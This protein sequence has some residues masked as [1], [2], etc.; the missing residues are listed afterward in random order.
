M[1]RILLFLL[2]L[3][4]LLQAQTSGRAWWPIAWPKGSN[5]QYG[6]V[7]RDYATHPVSTT[8]NTAFFANISAHPDLVKLREGPSWIQSARVTYSQPSR[9]LEVEIAATANIEL[10]FER[11]D[12]IGV[13]LSG[14]NPDG[15]VLQS[16]TY[17][18]AGGISRG[19]YN[20][21]W[22]FGKT[23]AGFGTGIPPYPIK[24]TFKNT[25]NNETFIQVFRPINRASQAILFVASGSSP[26]IT[27]APSWVSA[28]Y[29]Y[30]PSA[31]RLDVE[32]AG[33]PMEIKFERVDNVP[34]TGTNPDGPSLVNS[35][36]YGS[37]NL[38][39]QGSYNK[40]WRWQKYDNGTGGIPT[41]PIRIT[42][43][44]NS[45]NAIYAFV[46]TPASVTRQQLFL[47]G[48]TGGGTVLCDY[49]LSTSNQSVYCGS[50]ITLTVS[51]T[52]PDA[53]GVTYTW[54]GNGLN[55]TGQSV[56]TSAPTGNGSYAYTVTAVKAN[57]ANKTATV[58]VTVGG[59]SNSA[60]FSNGF[61]EG[62]TD[63]LMAYAPFVPSTNQYSSWPTG[64]T[65]QY[66]DDGTTKI[67]FG[68]PI[69][70][71]IIHISY[72]GGAN[73]VNTNFNDNGTFE[74]NE[75]P[76]TGRSGGWS[77]YG[78]PGNGYTEG[79]QSTSVYFD[80]G[81]NWVHGGSVYKNYS[82][83]TWYERRTVA[84]FGEVVYIRTVPYQW[85]LVNIPGKGVFHNWYWIDSN[86]VI[87]YYTIIENNRD[88][89][90]RV[91][92]F[93]QQEGPFIYPIAPLWHHYV[94]AGTAPGTSGSLTAINPEEPE[95]CGCPNNLKFGTQTT[96]S[97][98]YVASVSDA[99]QALVLIPQ[100]NSNFHTFQ[101]L[102]RGGDNNSNASSYINSATNM[103]FDENSTTAFGGYV[104]AGAWSGFRSWFNAAGITRPGFSWSFGTRQMA[105]WYPQN[106]EAKYNGD[107]RY[108]FRFVRAGGTGFGGLFFSPINIYKPSEI[109]YIYIKGKFSNVSKILIRWYKSGQTEL[110]ALQ[111]IGGQTRYWDVIGDGVERTYAIPMSGVTNWDGI[112]SQ[113][114]ISLPEDA[115]ANYNQTFVPT[116]IGNVNPN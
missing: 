66:I 7:L 55:A 58:T 113:I 65:V 89:T 35:T 104:Y 2:L 45:D 106:S 39:G 64:N 29:T 100:H 4:Q 10:R 108:Q 98:G 44:R 57:C 61:G 53:S 99:G 74:G 3:P 114:R 26:P 12:S 22:V 25:D 79:G 59:C 70:G 75:A 47:A 27:P 38:S 51:A 6:R 50:G 97:E 111:A 105:G 81:F 85:A 96:A 83:I 41:V 95:E 40:Q 13:P 49:T 32:A 110:Q 84:G 31:A 102:S 94:Y 67:G 43:K 77:M 11:S 115:T 36:Y 93:R 21:H 24:L 101:V 73:L 28:R 88:D 48:G 33:D 56:N 54:T 103:N 82:P 91:Y 14:G 71:A 9:H 90:Q 69:G 87:R 52:G 23:D 78:N 76:D 18:G 42:F 15:V 5:V 30:D 34:L 60:Y 8:G 17:Y 107:N 109:P 92:E 37:G 16:G 19:I 46:F 86:H 112:I 1:K 63:Q 68:K 20:K 62:S 116:Y 72:G 80:T